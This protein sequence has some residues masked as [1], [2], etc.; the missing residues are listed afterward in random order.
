MEKPGL[1]TYCKF[2]HPYVPCEICSL[3]KKLHFMN[4]KFTEKKTLNLSTSLLSQY[5]LFEC[6]Q[7]LIVIADVLDN[8][9]KT[10]SDAVYVSFIIW[11]ILITFYLL[12]SLTLSFSS[13]FPPFVFT[14]VSSVI[15]SAICIHRVNLL[16]YP[17]LLYYTITINNSQRILTNHWNIII[18]TKIIQ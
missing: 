4:T 8:K 9:Y 18:N 5:L 16:L 7:R 15:V 13:S 10:L 1:N 6:K 12:F 11:S 3:N 14:V 2:L 17:S